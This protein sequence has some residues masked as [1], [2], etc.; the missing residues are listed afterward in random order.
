LFQLDACILGFKHLK[1]L[2]GDEEDF[3]E[4]YNEHQRHPKGDCLLQEGYLFKGMWLCI[5]KCGT[6]VTT[7]NRPRAR[8]V[9]TKILELNG[10]SL[11]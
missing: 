5:P 4:I 8:S 6:S 2:Y 7:P 1:S 10:Q 11:P 9:G 3:N